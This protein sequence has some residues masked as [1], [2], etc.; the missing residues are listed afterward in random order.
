MSGGKN[1]ASLPDKAQK[2]YLG[3]FSINTH[4]A[5]SRVARRRAGSFGG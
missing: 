4:I 2:V 3:L 1:I 5:V